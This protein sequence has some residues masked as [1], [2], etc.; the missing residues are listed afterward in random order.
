MH[1]ALSGIPR[2]GPSRFLSIGT[3]GYVLETEEVTKYFLSIYI[4]YDIET[5]GGIAPTSLIT[6]VAATTP[7]GCTVHLPMLLIKRPTPPNLGSFL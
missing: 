3:Y 5:F 4:V 2:R 6:C 7:C 1:G